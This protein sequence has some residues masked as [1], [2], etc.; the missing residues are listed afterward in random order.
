[1][2]N[3][4]K[5]LQNQQIIE[6]SL[7]GYVYVFLTHVRY[8][9]LYIEIHNFIYM[10]VSAYV[11]INSQYEEMVLCVGMGDFYSKNSQFCPSIIAYEQMMSS[12]VQ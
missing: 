3:Y 7:Y 6:R 9:R 5:V 2:N 8:A 1:L 12:T 10:Y 11:Y 4:Q